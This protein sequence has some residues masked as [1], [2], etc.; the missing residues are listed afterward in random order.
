MSEELAALQANN[1]WSL[2]PRPADTNVVSG[3]WVFWH[4]FLPDGA[5]D[6]YKAQ[7]VL[8]GFTQQHGVDNSET[9]SPAVKPATI[10]MVLSVALS[11][12]WPIHQMDVKNT[13][14]HGTLTETIYCEQPSGFVDSSH[15][16]YVCH[17][18]KSLYGLKQAHRA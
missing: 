10:R 18:N 13:F 5:L 9:F 7:W 16:N 8:R 11:H 6:R 3:K 1:T 15:P 17:L 4:K 2:V 12:N 14:L